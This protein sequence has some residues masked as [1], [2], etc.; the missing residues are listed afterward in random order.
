[1]SKDVA[2]NN[3]VNKVIH[4]YSRCMASRLRRYRVQQLGMTQMEFGERCLLSQRMISY[5]ER[6]EDFQHFGM[7]QLICI[8]F[9]AGVFPSDILRQVEL[10]LLDKKPSLMRR[11]FRK[12]KAYERTRKQWTGKVDSIPAKLLEALFRIIWILNSKKPG[13]MNNEDL[14]MI[15]K[16]LRKHM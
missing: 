5:I 16:L 2:K 12:R 3:A 9:G 8:A 11:F 13:E 14:D 15:R 10:E 4:E 6:M 1:M 7:I